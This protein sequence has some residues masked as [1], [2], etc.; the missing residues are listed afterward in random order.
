MEAM[1][2]FREAEQDVRVKDCLERWAEALDA[3][4]KARLPQPPKT[5]DKIVGAWRNVARHLVWD[6]IAEGR[7]ADAAQRGQ[8]FLR[9]DPNSV[10]LLI[11]T[12]TAWDGNGDPETAE[13]LLERSLALLRGEGPAWEGASVPSDDYYRTEWRKDREADILNHLG[14]MNAD[15]GIQLAGAERMIR[16]SLELEGPRFAGRNFVLEGSPTHTLDSLGWVLYKQNRL[17]A[18]AAVFDRLFAPDRRLVVERDGPIH[19]IIYD[20]AGDV[21]YRLGKKDSAIEMWTGALRSARSAE[22]SS[23]TS[24]VRQGTPRK[25]EALAKGRVPP[26]A[27]LG[28]GQRDDLMRLGE[29]QRLQRQGDSRVR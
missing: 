4:A 23:D 18:A 13:E 16:R 25:L 6:L 12:A 20:H 11:V 21:F 15:R 1:V 10:E 22:P 8:G 7:F 17:R 5:R 9:S 2:A 26:V 24:Q 3:D 29:D 19:P 27:P 28:R 14:Y